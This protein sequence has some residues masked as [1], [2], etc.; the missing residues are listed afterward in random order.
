M[1][2][3][4]GTVEKISLPEEKE[5]QVFQAADTVIQLKDVWFRYG[6]DLPDVVKDLSLEVKEGQLYCIVA[7]SYTHLDVYKRQ[8]SRCCIGRSFPGDYAGQRQWFI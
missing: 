6:R 5:N 7:V 4:L 3:H 2:A 8:V 1:N